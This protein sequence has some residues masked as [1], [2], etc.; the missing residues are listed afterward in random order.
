MIFEPAL[1]LTMPQKLRRMENI[2][3]I[4]TFNYITDLKHSME[5]HV[6]KIYEIPF[7]E[8]SAVLSCFSER[9]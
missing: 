9:P 8:I 3:T 1:F 5:L 4:D 6:K 7:S 2:V